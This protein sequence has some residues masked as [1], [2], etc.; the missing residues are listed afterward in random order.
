MQRC[1]PHT[2][3]FP[4]AHQQ[5]HAEI[6]RSWNE[7]S[8]RYVIG[9]RGFTVCPREKSVSK[10]AAHI[11]LEEGHLNIR[12]YLRKQSCHRSLLQ[13]RWISA[14]SN[15]SAEKYSITCG[16]MGRNSESQRGPEE[17]K[18]GTERCRENQGYILWRFS[19]H[20]HIQKG[21]LPG[22]LSTSTDAS[23]MVVVFREQPF[24]QIP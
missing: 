13:G 14:Q 3:L 18:F 22:I 5:G 6:C 1:A 11:C 7:R 17:K 23:L 4:K 15:A 12:K 8:L 20:I 16:A 9:E 2:Q 21:Y 19:F 10:T 24:F